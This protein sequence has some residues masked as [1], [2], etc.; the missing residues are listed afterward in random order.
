[1]CVCVHVCMCVCVHVCVCVC[2]CARVCVVYVCVERR[3]IKTATWVAVT[4]EGENIGHDLAPVHSKHTARGR[5]SE[6]HVKRDGLQSK[7][8]D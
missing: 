4:V 8:T 5:E 3:I 6:S 2:V 7:E 1:M